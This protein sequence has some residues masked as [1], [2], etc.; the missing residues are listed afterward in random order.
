MK[1]KTPEEYLNQTE[2]AVR[3]FYTGLSSCWDYYEKALEHWDISKLNH[4]LTPEN[5]AALDKYLEMAGKY[6]DLKFSEATFAGAIFQ[7]AAMGIR[8]FSRNISIPQACAD[9]VPSKFKNIIPFCIGRELQGLPVGLIIY[10]ARNQY[11]HWDE[12]PHEVTKNVFT[13]LSHAFNK[14]MLLDLAFYIGNPSI[15]IYANEILFGALGWSTYDI[16]FSE[17]KNLLCMD[18]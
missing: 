14:D 8:Y 1:P 16:Y 12:E 2:H 7:V 4:P 11:I 10:A 9:I 3:H 13:R 6:F 15:T 18:N 17:M 5:K